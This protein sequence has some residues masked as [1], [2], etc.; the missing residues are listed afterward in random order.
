MEAELKCP[1]P[2]TAIHAQVQV[3][4]KSILSP[5][6]ST[7]KRC[8]SHPPR[9]P[10][11]DS[12][13]SSLAFRGWG[14]RGLSFAVPRVHKAC[15]S[16]MPITHQTQPAH[17]IRVIKNKRREVPAET[18]SSPL[19]HSADGG[20]PLS[21][22]TRPG[23]SVQ[24]APGPLRSQTTSFPTK[25]RSGWESTKQVQEEKMVVLSPDGLAGGSES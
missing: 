5:K 10:T 4:T 1:L 23:A 6:H 17:V 3:F 12:P 25:P 18:R 22:C 16:P 2:R 13:C 15:L 20:G 8:G 21:P 19:S 7:S 9:E 14:G 24:G 11:V